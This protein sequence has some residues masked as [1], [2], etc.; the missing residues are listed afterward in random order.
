MTLQVGHGPSRQRSPISL[1]RITH[2]DAIAPTGA[3]IDLRNALQLGDNE[4]D[5]HLRF[6]APGAY[7]LVLETDARAQSHLPAIRFNDYLRSEGL[8]PALEQRERTHRMDAD[9]SEHYSRAAKS[10]VQVG[11]AGT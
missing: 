5:G 2:F 4:A 3:K 10:I 9:G 8:S 11:T 1:S 6:D 7:V